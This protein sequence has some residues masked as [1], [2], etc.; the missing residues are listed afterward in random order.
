[1]PENALRPHVP[2]SLE[3]DTK[4]GVAWVS[5]VA[6]HMACV[7][8]RWLPSFPPVSDFLELNLRTYVRKDGRPGVFF[9][10]IHASKRLAVRVAKWLSPL[11]YAYA[12]MNCWQEKGRRRFQSNS[13]DRE[14]AAFAAHYHAKSKAY[15]DSLSEWLLERY[16][17]YA[18]NSSSRLVTTE[19]QHAPWAVQDVALEI[20][21]NTLGQAFGLDLAP[22]PDRTHFSVGVNALA[23]SFEPVADKLTPDY[24]RH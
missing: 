8:P 3:I 1:M 14:G 15:R 18:G 21:S 12:R 20:S 7:R 11:P 2:A 4:D 16:C 17:L 19:V 23:W 6:F 13:V 5:A 22:K 9:L 10:S 24:C